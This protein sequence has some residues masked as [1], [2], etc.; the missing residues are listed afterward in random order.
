MNGGIGQGKPET[1]THGK[2]RSIFHSFLGV[3]WC[4]QSC[5]QAIRVS[6]SVSLSEFSLYIST[7]SYRIIESYQLTTNFWKS[8][9]QSI[10]EIPKD[11][12]TGLEITKDLKTIWFDDDDGDSEIQVM[13][14]FGAALKFFYVSKF[15]RI[16]IWICQPFLCLLRPRCLVAK[17][18]QKNQKGRRP[19]DPFGDWLEFARMRAIWHLFSIPKWVVI[20]MFW[21]LRSFIGFWGC[22]TASCSY[23]FTAKR[24]CS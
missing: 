19:A 24:S 22:Y 1:S 17:S 4:M 11:N 9:L 8:G 14:S 20:S 16:K 6:V 13:I 12:F 15:T 3:G 18:V 10:V 2:F 5:Y 23:T 21:S 7:T